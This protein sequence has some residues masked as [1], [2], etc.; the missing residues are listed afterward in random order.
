MNRLFEQGHKRLHILLF[1]IALFSLNSCISTKKIVYFNDIS[2][3]ASASHPVTIES[4]KYEDP[5]I[6][7]NDVLAITLQTIEQNEGNT[8]ITTSSL[9]TFSPLNGFLVDKNGNI[10]LSL[11]GFIHVGGLTTSEARELIKDKANE[12]Y[13][14]PVVNVRISNFEV[15]LIGDVSIPGPHLFPSEKVNIIEAI[16]NGGDL[17]ITGK[18]KNVLLIRTEG[19]TRKFIRLDLTSSDIFRSPY[20]Y[21]RQRDILYVEPSKYKIETSDNR[22]TRNIG[23]ITSVISVLTIFLAFRNFK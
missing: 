12:Y 13:K 21:L 15:N 9:G 5:K 8:P 16:A 3:S 18:R 2:D 19:D 1:S 4:M 14:Q 22:L 17:T 20:F 10:E 6:L 7:P 23:I 11:I